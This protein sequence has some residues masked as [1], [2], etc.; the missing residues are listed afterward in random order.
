MRQSIASR[1]IGEIFFVTS[2]DGLGRALVG[3]YE[4]GWLVEVGSKDF[5]YAAK[6][7]RFID[8]IPVGQIA[9]RAGREL[10]KPVRNYR[11][12]DIPVADD[13]RGL[14][15]A[16]IDRTHDYLFE[17]DRLERMSLS[18]TGFRYPSWDRVNAFTWDVAAPYLAEATEALEAPN[19]SGTGTW[20]CT[21]CGSQI[22]NEARLKI[23]NVCHR[24]GTLEPAE[25]AG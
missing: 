8:P 12:I 3:M 22:R 9:G 13:V 23:C 17:I 25:V 6:G 2:V 1:G 5:A 21:A 10:Q 20:R 7:A 24:F 16:S 19:T 11:I 14:V 18:R 15:T 4:L